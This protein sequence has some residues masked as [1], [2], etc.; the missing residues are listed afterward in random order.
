MNNEIKKSIDQC[1]ISIATIS[2]NIEKNDNI[3]DIGIDSLRLVELIL[4][5]EE[6][7]NLQ[8]SNQELEPAS[9]VTVDDIYNLVEKYFK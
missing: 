9:I 3:K 4:T 7:F 1:I 5:L 6:T 2:E 8:F